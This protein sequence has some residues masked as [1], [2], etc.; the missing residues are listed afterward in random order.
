M[1]TVFMRG[2]RSRLRPWFGLPKASGYVLLISGFGLLK[3][4]IREARTRICR[5]KG[6]V[7]HFSDLRLPLRPYIG[8]ICVAHAT[9]ESVSC[10]VVTTAITW[11]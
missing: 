6:G 3:G 10:T 9:D 2:W 1:R 11:T 8:T 5:I 4:R 7:L